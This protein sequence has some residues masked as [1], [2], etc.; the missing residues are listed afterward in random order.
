MLPSTGR[1]GSAIL[2]CAVLCAVFCA[3]LYAKLYAVL[4][5][6]LCRQ[7]EGRTKNCERETAKIGVPNSSVPSSL[8]EL[9]VKQTC[10]HNG[11]GHS[12]Q[13]TWNGSHFAKSLQGSRQEKGVVNDSNRCID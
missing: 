12:T 6:M 10:V 4:Y 1:S 5:A 3:V 8:D 9:Q 11:S 7:L 13:R 2:L